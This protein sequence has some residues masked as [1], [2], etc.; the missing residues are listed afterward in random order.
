MFKF[1]D[2]LSVLKKKIY[3]QKK[4]YSF[5]GCDLL[6]DYI[7]KFKKKGLYLDVGC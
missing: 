4:S 2:K 1:F 6:I 3:S 5:G 7:F